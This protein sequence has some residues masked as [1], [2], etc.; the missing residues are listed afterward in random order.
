M[1]RL[2]L[3]LS[4]TFPLSMWGQT[5]VLFF[6]DLQ[7][8][9]NT[10]G[11]SISGYS[12]AYVTLYGNYFGSSQ[13][14]STATLNN[15][16]CLRVVSWGTTWRWYQ[17][18]VVQLGP[19][20]TSGN[21]VVSVGGNASNATPFT[22]NT[23][24]I[25]Y[26]SSSGSDSNS[27]S[28]ASPWA[29]IPHAVQTAGT[30]AG[31]IIYVGN[32]VSQTADDGQ[33]WDAALTL[34]T[35]DCKGTASQM[36]AV[37]A[38]PGATVQ[39]GPSTAKSPSNGLRTTDFTAGGGACGGHWTFAGITFRGMTAVGLSGG[40]TWRMVGNDISNPQNSSGSG[41]AAFETSQATHVSVLG[42]YFHDLN[43]NDTDRL[44]QGVYFSTDSN[45]TELGWSEIYNVWGRAG[46]QIHSSPIASGTGYAMFDLK[47]HDNLFHHIKE[48]GILV[49]TV[50]PSQ[51][52]V[53]V[54]NNV[55]YDANFDG[56]G[57]ALYRAV[58]SDF[59]TSHG[60]GSGT[61]E[62]F[63]NTVYCQNAGCWSS[64][65]EVAQGQSL[66]DDV[67]NN[68]LYSN[69]QTYWNPG[70]SRSGSQCSP[71]ATAAQCPNFKGTNNLVYGAGTPTFTAILANNVNLNPN[72]VTLGSNFQ[73][74]AGS[75]AIG[76]GITT[77][78]LATYDVDGLARPSP[79]SIGA[80]E[81]AA[82]TVV[83]LNPPTNLTATVQ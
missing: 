74:Q 3:L 68:L 66:T 56:G 58:S 65:F 33:G 5:P 60:A 16:S 47:I 50:D 2:I 9:P 55:V 69:S 22:V 42:D 40:D 64:S 57:T 18:I 21:F 20:C 82:G 15:L 39:I 71:G 81:V 44:E 75:P 76:A 37:L 51:G 4:L 45:H 54:Y 48:E 59:D 11:E 46:L 13:G 34:R 23:G 19:S 29:T 1:Q 12:G 61:V 10:G 6:S 53:Q 52:P 26:V 31:N 80:Y 30:G 27:G 7:N 25:Y 49:D 73:L 43:L 67:R 63:N 70:I 35:E 28:F 24:N 83:K 32:G 8:G 38:Y 17:K 78:P 14:S 72:F 62:W 36:D 79:P 77:A 41:G